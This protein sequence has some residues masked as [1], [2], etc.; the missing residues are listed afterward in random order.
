MNRSINCF[1]GSRV[2]LEKLTVSQLVKKVFAF[3]GTLRF[4]I[5]FTRTASSLKIPLRYIFILHSLLHIG[6]HSVLFP[7]GFSTKI[8]HTCISFSQHLASRRPEQTGDKPQRHSC[9]SA[10]GGLPAVTL[11]F[12]AVHSLHFRCSEETRSFSL[13]RAKIS[14][15]YI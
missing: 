4:V 5:A 10:M 7:S 6:L 12:T 14:L 13:L 15:N 3:N 8:L 1:H 11:L 9:H 2:F